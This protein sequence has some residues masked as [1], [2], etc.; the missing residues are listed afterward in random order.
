MLVK[1]KIALSLSSNIVD[2]HEIE[3]GFVCM[4]G[5]VVNNIDVNIT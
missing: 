5:E 3:T 1:R 4:T 2:C